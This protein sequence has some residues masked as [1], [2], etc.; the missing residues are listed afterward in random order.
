MHRDE[1][2]LADLRGLQDYI[3]DENNVRSVVV[4]SSVD[5]FLKLRAA[6][7]RALLGKRLGAK[8]GEVNKAIAALSHSALAAFKESGSI[9]VGDMAFNAE[10]IILSWEFTGDSKSYEAV[11]QGD[12]LVFVN[13]TVDEGLVQE[14]LARE[15]VNRVQKLRKKAGLLPSDSVEVFYEAAVQQDRKGK[16]SAVGA[17][18]ALQ[19]DYIAR[20]VGR[21][22]HLLAARP[23]HA[24]V[25]I[26]EEVEVEEER[27]VV[28]IA[29]AVA[30]VDEAAVSALSPDV[31]T[32]RG[33]VSYVVTRDYDALVA[34]SKAASGSVLSVNFNGTV[35]QLIVGKHVFLSVEEALKR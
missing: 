10:E 8:A 34:E 5:E 3:L 33:L 22:A 31:L 6:P 4:S 11:S 18:V 27:L 16:P 30:V 24:V 17:A 20:S 28:C 14:G 32:Q 35:H 21:P 2:F 1:Q 12:L 9:T 25:I 7:N 26:E 19:G 13:A 15:F 23:P 29:R